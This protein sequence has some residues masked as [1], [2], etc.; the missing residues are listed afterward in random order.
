MNSPIPSA[1]DFLMG[2]SVPS[3][4]FPQIGATVTGTICEPPVVQQQRDYT[5]GELK[6]WSDGNPMMQLVVTLQTTERDPDIVDDDGRRRVYVRGQLKKAVQRAVKATG[7]PGLEV[8]GQLT[9]TYA[10]DGQPTN[11]RFN[12]P[13]EY[14]ATYHPPAAGATEPTT[15]PT[16]PAQTPVQQA[17]APAVDPNSP[18]IQ[19][20]LAQI[21]Q[22]QQPPAA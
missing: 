15:S 9:V 5:T 16:A 10:R 8:G 7:A 20:L 12:P 2:E 3:A 1:N 14:T 22:G 6:F 17:P 4:K 18:E 13:K 21:Q 19:A 11:P